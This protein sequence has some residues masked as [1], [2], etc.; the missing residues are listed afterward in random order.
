MPCPGRT[1]FL[2]CLIIVVFAVCAIASFD[3]ADGIYLLDSV[4]LDN[5]GNI[6]GTAWQGG[7]GCTIYGCGTLWEITPYRLANRGRQSRQSSDL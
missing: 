3:G 7:Q 6:Y 1:Q 4:A 2:F 5:A